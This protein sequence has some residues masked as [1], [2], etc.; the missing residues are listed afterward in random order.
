MGTENKNM[1]PRFISYDPARGFPG[2]MPS[3]RYED[4]GGAIA[5]LSTAFGFKEHLR[6]TNK[7]CVVLHAEM[8][9]KD[10]FIELSRAGNDYKSPRQLGGVSGTIIVFV[11]DVNEHY[12]QALAAAARILAEPEDKPWGLRQYT[13]ED[14]EGH[15]FEF[16]QFLKDVPYA[17]WGAQL[18]E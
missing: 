7:D 14:I 17:S 10:A 12:K 4:V 8:R 11:E 1:D 3:L 15:R 6:W 5:W 13:A 16:S 2:V 9:I 18:M